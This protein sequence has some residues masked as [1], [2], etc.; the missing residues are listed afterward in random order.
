MDNSYMVKQ[1]VNYYDKNDVHAGY[2]TYTIGELREPAQ[3]IADY[4]ESQ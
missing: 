4:L 2:Q 1:L 3:K